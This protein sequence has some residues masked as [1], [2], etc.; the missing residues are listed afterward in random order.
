[1]LYLL[2]DLG[3]KVGHATRTVDQCLKYGHADITV[4]TA[5]LDAR[6]ILGDAQLFAEFE[7]RFRSEVVKGSARQFI[8]AKMAERDERTRRAGESRYKVEPNIKDGKGGL[9][10]SPHAAW[11]SKYIFGQEVG[12]A[13]VEAGI[14]TAGRGTARSGA[15][16]IFFGACVVSCIS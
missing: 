15:A 14:F 7:Q 5:L 16:R 4:R 11:L 2:W 8:D 12:T 13:A 1:M 9:P 3:F 10:R 6:L